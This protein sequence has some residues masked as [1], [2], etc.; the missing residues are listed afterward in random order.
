[1]NYSFRKRPVIVQA[2]QMTRARRSDK[3]DWPKWLHRAWDLHG[4]GAL[5]IDADDP[6]REKLVVFTKDGVHPV[7]WDDWIIRGVAGELYHCKPEIFAATHEPV[8]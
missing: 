6:E 5:K 4:E 1:M 3:S 7:S 8:E 2:F